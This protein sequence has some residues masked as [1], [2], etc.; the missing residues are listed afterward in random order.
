MSI[1]QILFTVNASIDDPIITSP[2][3]GATGLNREAVII[4]VSPFSATGSAIPHVS[5]DWQI[6][7]D[8][9]FTN[10]VQQSI[11]D[12]S[13]LESWITT[14]PSAGNYYIRVRY[15]G[16]N[17]TSS[18]WVSLDS[19]VEYTD[20]YWHRVVIGI[21]AGNGAS[22]KWDGSNTQVGGSG[23]SGTFYLD[24]V[25]SSSTASGSIAYHTGGSASG[26]GGGL[27]YRFGGSG[28]A[29]PADKFSSGGGG[30][31]GAVFLNGS[32]IAGVGGGGGGGGRSGATEFDTNS[33]RGG[34]GASLGGDQYLNGSDGLA[35]ATASPGQGGSAGG[36][37][38]GGNGQ[39]AGDKRN[40]GGGGAGFSGGSGG[41]GGFNDGDTAGGGGG[42]S[43]TY[44]LDGNISGY[45]M[46]NVSGGSSNAFIITRYRAPYSSPTSW[47]Q[48]GQFST[49]SGNASGT[50]VIAN[51]N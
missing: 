45:R 43:F 3:S 34:N 20:H 16:S 9:G 7:T 11:G 18:N 19:S 2:S 24:Q 36:A 31:S 41:S 37:S 48:V 28:D 27:G 25:D 29:D 5:T 22:G 46:Y 50:L 13:N 49:N 6:A 33:V 40:C 47:S 23:G 51:I 26:T 14:L 12:T 8:S 39:T 10:V 32:L 4:T 35:Y 21:K 15:N 30:G 1:M 38:N 17:N 42:A 44:T